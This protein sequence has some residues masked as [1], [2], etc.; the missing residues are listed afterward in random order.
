[1]LDESLYELFLWYLHERETIRI[2]KA[3]GSV[4]PWTQDKILQNYKFT[5]VL[6]ENDKTTKWMRDNWTNKNLSA[7]L[8]IQLLNCG[9]FRYFGSIEYAAEIGFQNEFNPEFLKETARRML[10]EKKKVFTGAYVITNNGMVGPKQDVVV[11][12]FLTPFWE[13]CPDIVRV[14]RDTRK[15]EF[16]T[17]LL[18]TV[19][20]FGG[21]GFMAKE[22]MSDAI[23][24]PVLSDCTDR[25][26]W[27]PVGPGA[28]RGL[29]RLHNRPLN[30]RIKEEQALREMDK[31]FLRFGGDF[32]SF[33]PTVGRE[34]DLHCVQFGLCEIDKYIRLRDGTGE[35]YRDW[36]TDRKSVV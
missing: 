33:M 35:V 1:M 2:K 28:L 34:F 4:R 8:E 32:K 13:M 29:N 20:G 19:S 30:A 25:Y 18:M 6:R 26:S 16:A 5:N 31:L 9:I 21:S 15:W 3:E 11:D 12:K 14:A 23:H 22:T 27:S 24:T 36:E 17:K 7:P 10:S